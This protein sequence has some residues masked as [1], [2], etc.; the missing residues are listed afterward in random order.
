MSVV[1]VN[2]FYW[3]DETATA[4]L[5]TDLAEGL[6]AQ[7]RAVTVITSRPPDQA[8]CESRRGV[9]ILRIG[10]TRARGA[11]LPAKALDFATFFA[12]ATAR[13]LR[14]AR[15]GDAIVALTDPPLIGAGA[16]LVA[17]MRGA[18][19]FHWVQDIYPEIALALTGRP[20]LRALSPWRDRAWRGAAGCVTLGRNMAGVIARAGVAPE[21]IRVLANWAPAGLGPPGLDE[22]GALRAAWGLVGKFVVGYS[23]NFGRVHDLESVLGLAAV[24]ADTPEIVFLFTGGGP[25][26]LAAEEAARRR[27]LGNVQFRPAQPRAALPASLGVSDLHLVTL[28]PGC[29]EYVFPSKIYGIA[30]VGRPVLFLGP[31]ACEP[32]RVVESAGFGRAF[33]PDRLPA[34]AAF[35]RGLCAAPAAGVALR[36]AALRFSAAAGGAPAAAAAWDEVLTGAAPPGVAAESR[37]IL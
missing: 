18:R 26:R 14:A 23:G 6:A 19:C 24:V 12:G 28:R 31:R 22:T 27:N 9:R 34:A 25:Q 8:A 11:G 21:R 3:P 5:L 13:L 17:R 4:Q 35:L 30:A 29:E 37:P 32:A 15:R 36:A 16:W 33:S 10:S 7:G 2:R 1:F 20:E